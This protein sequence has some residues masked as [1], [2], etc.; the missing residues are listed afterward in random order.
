[1]NLVEFPEQNIV[2]AKDQPQYMPMPAHV[3]L[4]ETGTVTCCWDLSGEEIAEIVKTGKI[5]HSILTYGLSVQPQ[6]L[7]AFKPEMGE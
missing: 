1:M 5:W 6:L 3:S 2:I 4:N 7:S